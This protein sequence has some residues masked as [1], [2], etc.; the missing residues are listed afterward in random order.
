MANWW[1]VPLDST[2]PVVLGRE[3]ICCSGSAAEQLLEEARA[4]HPRLL[5][6]FKAE[7]LLDDGDDS[8]CG[9]GEHLPL[10][11]GEPIRLDGHPLTLSHCAEAFL[12]RLPSPKE[13]VPLLEKLVEKLSSVE[14]PPVLWAQAAL[15][16]N[17]AGK[18]VIMLRE[19]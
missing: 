12:D 4:L 7:L 16:H 6:G 17:E 11:G 9:G 8:T 5:F 3:R 14:G 1:L 19:G 2:E 15:R 10:A 18:Y 13:A